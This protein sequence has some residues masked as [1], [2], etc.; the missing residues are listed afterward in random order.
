MQMQ[1]L[2]IAVVLLVAGSGDARPQ[3]SGR[4]FAREIATTMFPCTGQERAGERKWWEGRG[5]AADDVSPMAGNRPRDRCTRVRGN[6]IVVDEACLIPSPIS[7][8]L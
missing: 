6:V 8:I 4:Y 5:Q 2:K 1:L 7:I 3:A